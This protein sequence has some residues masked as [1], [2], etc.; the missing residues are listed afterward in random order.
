MH[1]QYITGGHRGRG[2]GRVNGENELRTIRKE[3]S[4]Q[5]VDSLHQ[6]STRRRTE[7]VFMRMVVPLGTVKV[8]NSFAPLPAILR[9]SEREQCRSPRSPGRGGRKRSTESPFG[10]WLEGIFYFLNLHS[11]ILISAIHPGR[12]GLFLYLPFIATPFT[13][14]VLGPD[15]LFNGIPVRVCVGSPRQGTLCRRT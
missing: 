11:S 5:K 15:S 6:Q 2:R 12:S 1:S 4:E 13:I 7:R 14:I 3:P 8:I 9:P 10:G